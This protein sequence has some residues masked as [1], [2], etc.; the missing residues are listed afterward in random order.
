[1]FYLLSLLIALISISLASSFSLWG[2]YGFYIQAVMILAS[3]RRSWRLWLACLAALG[4]YNYFVPQPL[5]LILLIIFLSIATYFIFD[6]WVDLDNRLLAPVVT[7][8]IILIFILASTFRNGLPL[9]VYTGSFLL[10]LPVIVLWHSVLT[11]RNRS[12]S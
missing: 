11:T 10:T 9:K 3:T 2:G 12:L 5:W 8:F 1:M 4:V 6:R 7:S